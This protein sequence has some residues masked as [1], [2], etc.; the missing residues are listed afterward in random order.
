MKV[1]MVVDK[2]RTARME[3]EVGGGGTVYTGCLKRFLSHHWCNMLLPDG[4]GRTLTVPVK[5]QQSDSEVYIIFT[6]DVCL[7][8]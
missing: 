2:M 8:V 1:P 4:G 6:A 3:V 7:R 5:T